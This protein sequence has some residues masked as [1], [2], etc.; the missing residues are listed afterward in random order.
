MV[1][2]DRRWVDL[3]L[4]DGSNGIIN[5]TGNLP[6]NIVVG[7]RVGSLAKE[8]VFLVLIALRPSLSV[9]HRHI[10]LDFHQRGRFSI[11][12]SNSKHSSGLCHVYL[13]QFGQ[14]LLGSLQ[15]TSPPPPPFLTN[16]VVNVSTFFERRVLVLVGL[17]I[18]MVREVLDFTSSSNT[19]LPVTATP[20]RLSK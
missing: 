2:K 6:E 8:G 18:V 13:F 11:L 7:L 4:S 3:V 9:P 12:R 1:L 19:P 15:G 5:L 16:A 17:A 14:Y 10:R 20:A